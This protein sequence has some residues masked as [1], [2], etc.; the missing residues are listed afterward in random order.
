M[1]LSKVFYW[2]VWSAIVMTTAWERQW[3]IM[4]LWIVV[5]II[6]HMFAFERKLT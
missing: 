6:M 1:K 3:T 2:L 4:S 5:G